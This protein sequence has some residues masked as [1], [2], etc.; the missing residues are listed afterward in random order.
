MMGTLFRLLL[1]AQWLIDHSANPDDA[2]HM[3]RV[4]W[5]A[6]VIAAKQAVLEQQ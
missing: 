6:D 4:Q 3:R 2:W 5:T 1:E